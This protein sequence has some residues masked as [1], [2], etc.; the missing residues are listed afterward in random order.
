MNWSI[1]DTIVFAD[2]GAVIVEREDDV[3]VGILQDTDT[4][5]TRMQTGYG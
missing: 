4:I 1:A 5:R 3:T 2:N